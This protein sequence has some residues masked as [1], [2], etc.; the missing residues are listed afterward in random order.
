MPH[1]QFHY[2]KLM[3]NPFQE[4]PFGRYTEPAGNAFYF[5]H[6]EPGPDRGTG[7]KFHISVDGA[8]VPKAWDTVVDYLLENNIGPA[9]V[10]NPG[11]AE[12]FSDPNHRQA[13]KM[14]TVYDF[15]GNVN[16]QRCMQDIE[17]LLDGAGVKPGHEVMGDKSIS[18]SRYMSYRNDRDKDGH[19]LGSEKLKYYPPHMHHNPGEWPERFDQVQVQPHQEAVQRAVPFEGQWVPQRDQHDNPLMSLPLRDMLAPEV[20]QLRAVLQDQGFKP[21][22]RESKSLGGPVMYVSSEDALRMRQTLPPKPSNPSPG[23]G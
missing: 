6:N 12:H 21:E 18:G 15:G 7:W 8:D 13:G 2:D 3:Q 20:S 11:Y 22:T 23:R 17:N 4:G 9:K 5:L 14:I 1:E 16:W 19:Y 10:V